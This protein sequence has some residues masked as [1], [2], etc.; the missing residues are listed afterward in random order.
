M[1][2][3]KSKTDWSQWLNNFNYG[4]E[5]RFIPEGDV[6]EGELDMDNEDLITAIFNWKRNLDYDDSAT[7]EIDG[8]DHEV[9]YDSYSKEFT[10]D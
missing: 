1:E 4:V 5:Y 8:V 7:L 2:Y 3:L 9:K 10:I 6:V